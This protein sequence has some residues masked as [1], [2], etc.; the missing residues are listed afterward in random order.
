MPSQSNLLSRSMQLFRER[1]G[2]YL[3]VA[4]LPYVTLHAALWWAIFQVIS[5]PSGDSPNLREVWLAMSPSDKFE[6]LVLSFL[7][8]ALPFAV[9]GFGLCNIA[10]NQ[11]EK[12]P[13]AFRKVALSMTGFLPSALPLSILVGA[14][15]LLGMC[16]LLV[17][18]V[19]ALTAFSLVVPAAS[20]EG[21]GPFAALR[22]GFSLMSRAFGRLLLCCFLYSLVV[23]FAQVVQGIILSSL[24][25]TL[26]ARVI[27][28]AVVALALLT[29]LAILNIC[30]TLIFYELRQEGPP[31]QSAAPAS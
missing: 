31:L 18:G 11:I 22:R 6:F 7:T 17:P 10:S 16:F 19:I 3:A 1:P 2:F 5:V 13:T 4:S 28:M 9:A 29:P 30:L 20:I 14:S 15:I 21:L 27:V 26:A 25:H 8:I 23:V 12:R 24:P